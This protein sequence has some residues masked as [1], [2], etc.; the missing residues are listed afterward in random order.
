MKNVRNVLFLINLEFIISCLIFWLSAEADIEKYISYEGFGKTI[1]SSRESF[2]VL[3]YVFGGL[4]FL[5][6]IVTFLY[7]K[8]NFQLNGIDTKFRLPFNI[9]VI[10]FTF[11]VFFVLNLSTLYRAGDKI[12][13]VFIFY[14]ISSFMIIFLYLRLQVFKNK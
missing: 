7:E 3:F 9:G 13:L 14:F 6:S 5:Y 4:I 2:L 11:L 12:D 10:L 8:Y 1:Y